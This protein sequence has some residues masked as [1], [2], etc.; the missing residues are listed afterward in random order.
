MTL[1]LSNTKEVAAICRCEPPVSRRDYF[2]GLAMQGL[3]I[4][5]ASLSRVIEEAVKLADKLIRE[6]DEKN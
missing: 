3:I 2:A 5:G 6:L 1:P 4:G